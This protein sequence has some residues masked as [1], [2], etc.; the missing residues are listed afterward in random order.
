VPQ[1][2]EEE[3]ERDRD[4]PRVLQREPVE[5]D[6]VSLIIDRLAPVG[7][8]LPRHRRRDAIRKIAELRPP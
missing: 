5:V 2:A 7:P 8:T 3:R 1:P 6:E 4:D